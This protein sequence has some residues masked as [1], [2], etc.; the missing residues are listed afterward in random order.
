MN[1]AI[2]ETFMARAGQIIDRHLDVRDIRSIVALAIMETEQ[3]AQAGRAGLTL[4]QAQTLAFIEAWQDEKPAPVQGTP[5]F[6]FPQP[7]AQND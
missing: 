2:P 7:A 1:T 4:L 6:A 3:S 5:D